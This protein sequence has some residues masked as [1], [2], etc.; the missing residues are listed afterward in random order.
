MDV[1]FT[2]DM[3][4]QPV[5]AYYMVAAFL[6]MPVTRIFM[7]AGLHPAFALLLLVPQVGY[8]FCAGVLALKKWPS[9][10]AA[11]AATGPGEFQP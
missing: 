11:D 9:A 8:I 4:Q 1:H 3:L 5:W 10:K 7:R 2:I 6:M